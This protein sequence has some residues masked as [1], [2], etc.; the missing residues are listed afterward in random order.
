MKTKDFKTYSKE[1]LESLLREKRELLRV[2]NFNLS[3]GKVKNVKEARELRKDVA[4]IFTL[5]SSNGK[6]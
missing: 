3:S 4:R 5:L 1:N 2:F 6:K